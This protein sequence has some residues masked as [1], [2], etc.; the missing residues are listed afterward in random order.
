MARVNILNHL[1]RRDPFG[2]ESL[3][4]H[5]HYFLRPLSVLYH[6][7]V[8]PVCLSAGILALHILSNFFLLSFLVIR[9]NKLLFYWFLLLILALNWVSP[10]FI[11]REAGF[12]LGIWPLKRL[13]I[14]FGSGDS[15]SHASLDRWLWI[16][17]WA[18]LDLFWFRCLRR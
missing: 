10:L 5:H 6:H 16:V 13:G 9:C 2:Q 8:A 14:R 11:T 18:S 12:C 1:L 4:G 3:L 7:V 15:S 17:F